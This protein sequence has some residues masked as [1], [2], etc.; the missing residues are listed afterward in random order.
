MTAN[1][2]HL[3]PCAQSLLTLEG[4]ALLSFGDLVQCKLDLWAIAYPYLC[5]TK[6]RVIVEKSSKKKKVVS[7]KE[8]VASGRLPSIT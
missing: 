1:S 7:G 5:S 2:S 3:W 6:N 4:P 8:N